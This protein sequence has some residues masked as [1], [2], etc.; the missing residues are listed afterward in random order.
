MKTA[1]YQVDE[2]E[3]L[4]RI[5]SILVESGLENISIRELCRRTGIA[6][7]SLYYWF[8]DKTTVICEATEYGLRKVTD[9]IFGYAFASIDNLSEFFAT[10]LEKVGSRKKE[11]RFLYQMA[12]SPEYG[13]RIRRDG[14]YFKAMYDKYAEKLAEMM[15]CDVERLRPVVYL[16]ISAI[17]DFAIWDDIENAQTEIDFIAKILPQILEGKIGG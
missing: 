2:N 7:G 1:T 16:F 12:S 10:C 6:Q 5:F 14:K 11:L 4:E 13:E 17:C 8:N 9:E 3:M 15:K